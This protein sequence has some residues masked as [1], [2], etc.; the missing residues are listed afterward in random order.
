ME[1]AAAVRDEDGA[2]YRREGS[3]NISAT[4]NAQQVLIIEEKK[5]ELREKLR[6]LQAAGGSQQS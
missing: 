5:E 4:A 1:C 2:D 6:Q 3:I